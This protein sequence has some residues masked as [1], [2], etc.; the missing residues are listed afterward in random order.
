MGN[1]VSIRVDIIIKFATIN[2][3]ITHPPDLHSF[4]DSRAGTTPLSHT[5]KKFTERYKPNKPQE[6]YKRYEPLKFHKNII[7]QN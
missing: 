1:V 5:F 2:K 6:R 4:F 7:N 3:M